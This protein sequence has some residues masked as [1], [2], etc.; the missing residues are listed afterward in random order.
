VAKGAKTAAEA[1]KATNF[2][3][4]IIFVPYLTSNSTAVVYYQYPQ[5]NRALSKL[6]FSTNRIPATEPDMLLNATCKAKGVDLAL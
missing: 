4:V 3:A 1:I 5:G 2:A 6:K